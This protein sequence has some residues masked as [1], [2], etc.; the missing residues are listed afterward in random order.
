MPHIRACVQLYAALLIAVVVCSPMLLAQAGPPMITDDPGTPARG[1]FEI[2]LAFTYDQKLAER[3][4]ETPLLDI[5]YG[6]MDHL[7]LKI[8][9]PWETTVSSESGHHPSGLGASL[10]GLKGRFLDEEK[11]GVAMSIYPQFEFGWS[12]LGWAH[13][14]ESDAEHVLL[15]VQIE[16]NLGL[17]TVGGEFGIDLQRDHKPEQFYG[18]VIGR[19]FTT[20]FE[21]LGEL[22][23]TSQPGFRRQEWL[24][25]GGMRLKLN[26][27]IALLASA[28]TTIKSD[29]HDHSKF[30]SYFAIQFNF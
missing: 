24:V 16:E 30:F 23:G 12:S 20:R 25:N 18:F 7:Q 14:N 19:E 3:S 8:E 22:R 26:A 15:P 10:V 17:V 28:G 27:F 6:L 11:F 4:I 5:N 2:N 1:H 9:V 29:E 13:D 21:L